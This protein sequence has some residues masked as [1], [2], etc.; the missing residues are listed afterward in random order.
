MP[1]IFATS[2]F[3][4]IIFLQIITDVKRRENKDVILWVPVA[5]LLFYFIDFIEYMALA[6]SIAKLIKNKEVSW[7]RWERVGVFDV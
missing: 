4:I 2:L 7:Q 3:S 5:W 6:K 1:M